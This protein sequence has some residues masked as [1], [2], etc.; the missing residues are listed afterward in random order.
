MRPIDA[1][2]LKTKINTTFFSEIGKI[3]DEAPTVE[4]ISKK[5]DDR[6]LQEQLESLS[7]QEVKSMTVSDL[8]VLASKLNMLLD[9][10]L[11]P[12]SEEEP[13]ENNQTKL[14]DPDT[15]I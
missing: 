2:A 9:I 14:R 10:H 6:S 8:A 15:N 7:P 5:I 12:L 1:D 11:T 3:I 4:L 13:N